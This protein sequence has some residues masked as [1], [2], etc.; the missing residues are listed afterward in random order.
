MSVLFASEE[1]IEEI[2]PV[3]NSL[4]TFGKK[5]KLAIFQASPKSLGGFSIK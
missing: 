2:D 5:V 4:V 1:L 3:V